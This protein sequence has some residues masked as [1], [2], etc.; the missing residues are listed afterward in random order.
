MKT[1]AIT[2]GIGS[3]KSTVLGILKEMGY[4]VYSCDEIY[5]EIINEKEYIQEISRLF[6]NV[7]EEERINLSKLSALVFSSKENRE[8]LNAVAHPKIM[9]QL[10][11]RMGE[12]KNSAL[13][14]A[15]VPLLFES[16]Y[17][18]DFDVNVVIMRAIDKKIRSVCKRDNTDCEQVLKR[19]QAQFDYE[20]TQTK[21]FFKEKGVVIVVND[22]TKQQL[23]N[24]I[25]SLIK[26]LS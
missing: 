16:G 5:R 15:E 14:F 22:G 7:V 20:S 11:K 6:P 8:K 4:P 1:I 23:K 9:Q 17:E 25:N 13:V 2:G 26:S 10:K 12:N 19:M 3:G 21:D 24:Q 18:K